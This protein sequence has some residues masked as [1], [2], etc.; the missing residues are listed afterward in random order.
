MIFRILRKQLSYRQVAVIIGRLLII[1][2]VLLGFGILAI[3]KHY[4]TY[5]HHSFSQLQSIEHTKVFPTLPLALSYAITNNQTAQINDI[6]NADYGLWKLVITDPEGKKVITYS[7]KNLEQEIGFID[8][9]LPENLNS[10]SYHL[11][12]NPSSPNAQDYYFEIG[13]AHV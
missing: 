6:L 11:L 13:R 12:I 2:F 10:Y 8:N 3:S 5:E 1:E 7:Q 9:R 4:Y